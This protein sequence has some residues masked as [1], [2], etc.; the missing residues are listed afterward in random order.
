MIHDYVW[1]T[2][3]ACIILA[4]ILSGTGVSGDRMRASL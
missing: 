4:I 3:A 1:W 2:G